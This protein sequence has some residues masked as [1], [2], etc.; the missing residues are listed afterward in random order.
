MVGGS[1][2]DFGVRRRNES[3]P[4]RWLVAAAAAAALATP[5][6]RGTGHAAD[7]AAPGTLRFRGHV[8]LGGVDGEF[9]RWRVVHATIDDL[10]PERSAVEV[11][12]DLAS[13]DTGNGIRDR[14]LKSESFLDVARYP[15][16]TVRLHDI[17]L[18]DAAAFSAEA[19]I[20]LHGQTHTLP[21]RFAIVDR[22]DRHITGALELRRSDFAV[23]T[24]RGGI[25]QVADE[26][27]VSV[28]TVVPPPG[29]AADGAEPPMTA[30]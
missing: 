21:M 1:R 11:E 5:Y 15:T 13:L 26:V 16:A 10:H 22:D 18:G 25:F 17:H 28:D 30:P 29:T 24:P 23:G 9:H 27:E 3:R 6:W 2:I 12:V 19:E 14:H 8:T 4:R 7:G 20:T